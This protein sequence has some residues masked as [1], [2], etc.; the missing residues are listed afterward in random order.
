VRHNALNCSSCQVLNNSQV[1]HELIGRV[2]LGGMSK[3]HVNP[4]AELSCIIPLS[5][6]PSGAR[7]FGKAEG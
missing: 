3:A 2:K 1:P 4:F 5:L 7:D 6:L